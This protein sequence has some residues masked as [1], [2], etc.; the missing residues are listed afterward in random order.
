[1]VRAYDQCGDQYEAREQ[2]DGEEAV[3]E[4]GGQNAQSRR[5]G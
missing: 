3:A 4:A 5:A 2:S 1:M